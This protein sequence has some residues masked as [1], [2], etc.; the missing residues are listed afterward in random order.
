MGTGCQDTITVTQEKNKDLVS[1]AFEVVGTGDYDHMGDYIADDYVRHCQ[2]TPDIDVQ[3]LSQ[4][5]EFIRNDRLVFPDQSLEVK[6]LIAENDYVAFW[7]TY[8]GTQTG[9]MGPFPPTNKPVSLDFAGLHRIE[10]G[11]IAETW[12]T[13]D[14]ITVLS[15]LGHFPPNQQTP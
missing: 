5:K 15:Q 11:R 12:I 9:Q 14:N 1:M 3:N 6:R 2:A 10:N 8:K 13:W 7:A 4:F